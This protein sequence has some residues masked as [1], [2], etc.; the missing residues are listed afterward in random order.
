MVEPTPVDETTQ[1]LGE[2]R[3]Q[4]L[5]CIRCRLAQGRRQV[6]FGEGYPHARIML[7]GQGPSESDDRS[8]HPYSGPSGP[9]LDQALAAAGL[10]RKDIW[11]TNITKCL[12]PA[13]AGRPHQTCSE[14]SESIREPKADEVRACRIWLDQEIALIQPKVIVCIGGPAAKA[15]IDP[16]FR[17]TEQRGQVFPGP[18]GIPTLAV[19]QPAYILRLKDH[20]RPAAVRAWNEL[21]ADLRRAAGLASSP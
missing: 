6:V 8:G 16:R 12:A 21:V 9:V 18:N 3:A 2:L 7:V 11:L 19:V 20:D 15:L 13:G 5:T 4:A 14:R 10:K 1:A 17:L